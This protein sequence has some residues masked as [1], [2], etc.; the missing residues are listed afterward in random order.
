M[1]FSKML[2][3][4]NHLGLYSEEIDPTGQ[5]VGNF[6]QAFTHLA[7]IQAVLRLDD[8]LNRRRPCTDLLTGEERRDAHGPRPVPT[9]RPCRYRH[10]RLQRPRRR[11]RPGT[12]ASRRRPGAGR[13]PRGPTGGHPQACR[14][15]RQARGHCPG[16][17]QRSRRR[18]RGRRRGHQRVRQGRHPRQQRR[19]RHRR[20]ATRETPEQF[21]AV[22][23]VNLNG[24]YWMAQAWGGS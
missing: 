10:R 14:S 11:V 17:H 9:R 20:P 13:P 2:T 1:T 7:L 19:R 23:D 21:R 24:C 18:Q 5:Q 15:R 16:R 22:I 4:A 6:P 8:Q 3:Y 12:R